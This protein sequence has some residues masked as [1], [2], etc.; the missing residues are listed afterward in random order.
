MR[1]RTQFDGQFGGEW[2]YPVLKLVEGLALPLHYRA[3]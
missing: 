2:G 3:L 1:E